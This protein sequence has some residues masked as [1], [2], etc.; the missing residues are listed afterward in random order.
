VLRPYNPGDHEDISAL[1][2]GHQRVA[3]RI[4]AFLDFLDAE[5]RLPAG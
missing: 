1:Y 4:R 3:S 2:V 5:L